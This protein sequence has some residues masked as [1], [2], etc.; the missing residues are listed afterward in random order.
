MIKKE[1][2]FPHIA[3]KRKKKKREDKEKHGHTSMHRYD[4]SVVKT[5]S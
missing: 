5:L 4:L 2:V 1:R 3:K